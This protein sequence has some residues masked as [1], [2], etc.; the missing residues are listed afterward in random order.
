MKRFIPLML[1]ISITGCGG[2]M[3]IAPE[4]GLITITPDMVQECEALKPFEGK[5]EAELITFASD[6]I[7]AYQKCDNDNHDK[8]EL[9]KK[10]FGV[11]VKQ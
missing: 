4:R 2:T 10:I 6:L 11:K 5:T 8:V 3:P 1:F 9:M 7:A